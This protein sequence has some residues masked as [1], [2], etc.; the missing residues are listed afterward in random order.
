MNLVFKFG[1]INEGHSQSIVTYLYAMRNIVK[2]SN[3]AKTVLQFIG[4]S[5]EKKST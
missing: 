4:N 1:V 2:A 3:K 5:L